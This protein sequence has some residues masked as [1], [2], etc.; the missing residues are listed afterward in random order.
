MNVADV[1]I[2][3]HRPRRALNLGGVARAMKNFGLMRL[4]LV[5][6]EI[7]SWAD[8]WRMAHKAEDV[9]HACKQVA[10]LDEALGEA[11]WIVGTTNRERPGQRILTPRELAT[12]AVRRG[13]PTILFGDENSGLG[14]MELLRCHDVATIPTAPEQSSLNLAQAVLLFSHELFAANH[15]ASGARA[16]E[17][18]KSEAETDWADDNLLRLFEQKLAHALMTS[19]WSNAK[20]EVTAFAELLQ[21]IRRSRPTRTEALAWLTA[22]NKIV[23]RDKGDDSTH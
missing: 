23:Q 19:S 10:T 21:P 22:L 13:P 20:R 12:E 5:A 18:A 9:L 8:A 17:A 6:S 1:H 15:E 7:G 3:L 14:N 4:T 11:T 2:V 16:A